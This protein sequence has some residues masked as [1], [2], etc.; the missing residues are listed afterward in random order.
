MR[1]LAKA[2]GIDLTIIVDVIHVTEYLWEAGRA[3]YPK[4]GPELEKWVQHRLLK[5]LHGKAGHMAG[6]MRRSAT[7]KG[8]SDKER[9][10]VD[11]CATYLLN[12]SS[13]LG[14]NRYLAEGLPIGTGVIEGACRHLVKDR[15]EI[16]GAKWTLNGA[17][18]VLRLRALRASKDFDAYW[19]FHEECEYKRNHQAHYANGTVPSVTASKVPAMGSHLK[20]IK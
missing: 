14:Y 3:F 19:T 11:K 2:K 12:K 18:A 6:G 8:F 17:E 5:I 15:M 7:R 4:S 9:E 20:I 1:W 16:T 13:Y 10:P